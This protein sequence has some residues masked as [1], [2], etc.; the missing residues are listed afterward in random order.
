METRNVKVSLETAKRWKSLG[1][2]FEQVALQTFPEL[3]I[4]LCHI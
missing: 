4:K 3:N 1:G 2:E